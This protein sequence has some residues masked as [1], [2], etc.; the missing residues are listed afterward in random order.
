MMLPNHA[1]LF[2]KNARFF[3][4]RF[5]AA[6]TALSMVEAAT[7][8]QVATPVIEDG[9]VVNLDI[10]K[11][12]LLYPKAGPDWAEEQIQATF[13]N[14]D[15]IVFD[16]PEICNVSPV[17]KPV[18]AAIGSY[19]NR[20]GLTTLEGAPVVDSGFAFVLGIGLGYHLAPLIERRAARHLVL[21]EPVAELLFHSLSSVD[22]EDIFRLARENDMD[23]HFIIA[24]PPEQTMESLHR[25][26]DGEGP[27]F[28]DGSL[29]YVHYATPA[30]EQIRILMNEE[31][32]LHFPS[33]G[34]FE[35]EM[36]M[37][38]NTYLNALNNP[39]HAIEPGEN[40][41]S[42]IPVLI[43]GSGPSL[44]QDIEDIK[45]LSEHALVVSCGTALSILLNN[46]IRPDIH[47]ENENHP[48][49]T[50]NLK[51]TLANHSLDGMTFIAPTTVSPQ[52]GALFE[53]RWYYLRD[54]Y[55]SSNALLGE[56]MAPLPESSPIGANVA[57]S[58][59]LA[60]GFNQIYLFG[61]DCGHKEGKDHHAEGS[62]YLDESYED[63]EANIKISR[64]E[65]RKV[66]GT[67]GGEVLSTP[68]WERSRHNMSRLLG[69]SPQASV[70]NC[71]DGAHI[72]GAM[73]HRADEVVL[74]APTTT[75]AAAMAETEAKMRF[76]ET[77][78]FLDGIDGL[79]LEAKT[80]AGFM[81]GFSRLIEAAKTEDRG[82]WEVNQRIR[83]FT[84]TNKDRY[85]GFL[86]ISGT[87]ITNMIRL[88]AFFGTRIPDDDARLKFL[89]F[90][91]D[92]YLPACR[93]MAKEAETLLNEMADR[94]ETLSLVIWTEKP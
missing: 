24:K 17:T 41:G 89:R 37:L 61:V 82:F 79:G 39:F 12:V 53:K 28:L 9:Q 68:L 36:L 23:I 10:G 34:F 59:L 64:W 56:N 35:D 43:I 52:A 71:S 65:R 32:R 76:F 66:P 51:K 58:A 73:P 94:H 57:L 30:M 21:I 63:P 74:P 2:V 42:S 67:F 1:D 54:H 15:R 85:R 90:F 77:G 46:A 16:S 22:W 31:L 48:R 29:A 18:F 3:Q 69:A 19:L 72:P 91:L 70:V 7:E 27:A 75:K 78:R 49:I 4:N 13:Q 45:R 50:E 38:H 5:P 80:C 88:G 40:P 92:E 8:A 87:T 44:N 25:L 6:W 81:D 11:G 14:P 86:A 20:H 33:L 62:V 26:I 84:E 55:C 83:T 93:E 60:L 47:V